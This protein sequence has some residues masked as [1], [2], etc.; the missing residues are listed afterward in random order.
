MPRTIDLAPKMPPKRKFRCIKRRKRRFYGD[1]HIQK[2]VVDPDDSS[3]DDEPSANMEVEEEEN[4]LTAGPVEQPQTSSPKSRQ[5]ATVRKLCEDASELSSDSSWDDEEKLPFGYR[6]FD[7]S[8]LSAMIESLLCP[9]CKSN[10]VRMEEKPH[11][12]MGFAATIQVTCASKRCFF[13]AEFPTS[14]KIGKAYDINSRAVLAARNI[15]VGH[16]GLAKC[17]GAM[18]TPPPMHKNAYKDTLSS[19]CKAA[20]KV[21]ENSM[22]QAAEETKTFYEVSDDSIHNVA[23]SCD[24]SWRRRGYA[25]AFG[26]VSAMSI[27]T[28]KVLDIDV[29]SKEYKTC[30]MNKT[31]RG[32]PEFDAWWAV[33]KDQCHANFEGSSG[34]MEP[35]GCLNIFRRSIDKSGL[36]YT[37]FLGDGDS[38][39]HN[40][41]TAEKVYGDVKV[42]KLEC[43]GHIQKRM[44]SQLR[45]LKTKSGRTHLSDGKP[46]GGQGRLTKKVI[47]SMQ[48]YYGKAIRDN[49]H[50]VDAMQKATMAILFHSRSTDQNPQH[51]F[52]PEGK[53]SWCGF[54]R[55]AANGT[56]EYSHR[57]PLPAAVADALEPVFIALSSESLLQACTHGGTQN[58]HE[59]FTALIWQRSTKQT[60]SGLPTVELSTHLAIAHFND[61]SSAIMK[62]LEEM[63]IDPG[64]LCKRSCRKLDNSIIYYSFVKSSEKAKRRRK[65]IRNRK[66]GFSDALEEAEGPQYQS[67]AF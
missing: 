42:E 14:K 47:D 10:N 64:R 36:R 40:Q 66:K 31:Q 61:G 30:M 43:V 25:S 18:N 23:I 5:P 17:L 2:S 63:G 67:G 11:S 37:E 48:V 27:V 39:A 1:Q 24:G 29:M 21:A 56:N 53:D 7:M 35:G 45:S 41:V 8:C 26:I 65:A 52:C 22:A 20:K 16:L 34:K 58:Q 33:H 59:S 62:I 54:Q 50:S 15:G 12:K 38:K 9:L 28:G 51:H 60:H 13:S 46:I 32:T 6:V 44:C 55:D 49:T 3:H 19:V 4:G 57:H